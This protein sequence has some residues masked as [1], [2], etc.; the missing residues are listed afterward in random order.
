MT[1]LDQRLHRAARRLREMPID[2]PPL[3]SLGIASEPPS[4]LPLARHAQRT[5]VMATV[6]LTAATVVLGGLVAVSAG[7]AHTGAQEIAAL[8]APA[9]HL[10]VATPTGADRTRDPVWRIA[11]PPSPLDEVAMLASAQPSVTEPVV[12]AVAS[13][14]GMMRWS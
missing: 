12:A 1:D 6:V 14:R 7:R 13:A 8:D 11:R 2:V 5:A 9:P 4:R 3:E 10:V